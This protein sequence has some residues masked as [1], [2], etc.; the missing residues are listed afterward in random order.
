MRDTEHIKGFDELERKLEH[1]DWAYEPIRDLMQKWALFVQHETVARGM[2]KRG[3]GGWRW[4]GE[5]AQSVTRQ[6]DPAQFPQYANVGSAKKTFR[7]G[8]FGTGL[9]SEDPQSSKKRH[10]PPA[11]PLD[12]WALAHG[13]KDG[14]EVAFIIGRRGGLRP[15]RYLRN[16]FKESEKR[17]PAWLKQC[18][19]DIQAAASRGV[20]RG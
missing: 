4:K 14:A 15:R 9:L 3:P 17:L 8:E 10:W 11:A 19:A 5:T 18:S 1:P 6:V 13:F 2:S 12:A 7:W 16:A 20:S